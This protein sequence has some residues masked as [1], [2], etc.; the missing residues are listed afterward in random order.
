MRKIIRYLLEGNGSVPVFVEDGGYFI[1]GHDMVGVSVD[2]DARHVPS[3]IVRLSKAQLIARI[4]LTCMDDNG[5]L[6][7]EEA[8]EEIANTF[9][10]QK[11]MVDY[12]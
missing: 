11:G 12:E 2:E 1:Q 8:A 5:D 6:V 3:T 10:E 9:L 4:M 7:D